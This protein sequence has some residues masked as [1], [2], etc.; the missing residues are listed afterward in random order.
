MSILLTCCIFRMRS[1]TNLA[2]SRYSSKSNS[3]EPSSS[4]SSTSFGIISCDCLPEALMPQLSKHS[5]HSSTLSPLVSSVSAA[6]KTSAMR[7]FSISLI[8]VII[9]STCL[10]SK[11]ARS[12]AM[13]SFKSRPSS[14]SCGATSSAA[15]L[16]SFSR[17]PE[18]RCCTRPQ[19]SAR[20]S[21]DG[22]GSR[23]CFARRRNTSCKSTK[24]KPQRRSVC[25]SRS[26]VSA[27]SWRLWTKSLSARSSSNGARMWN[28]GSDRMSFSKK[29]VNEDCCKS[30]AVSGITSVTVWIIWFSLGKYP[31]QRRI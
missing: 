7:S 17:N 12:T 11:W 31:D 23:S 5:I 6:A 18:P 2:N 9:R 3:P 20:C 16:R 24:A 19:S 10:K 30:S 26:I 14:T 15:M 25:S 28:W 22:K 27:I 1:A 21:K 29:A 13:G 4:N 8:C